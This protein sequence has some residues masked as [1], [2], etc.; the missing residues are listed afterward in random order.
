MSVFA[1]GQRYLSDSESNLGLGV[2]IEVDDRCV[3]ILFPQAKKNECMPK[4]PLNCHG[5]SLAVATPFL[6]K[7]GK[8]SWWQAV[9][10]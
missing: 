5:W 4:R 9:K 2:V 3:H 1:I 8:S 7:T 10:R 6:T